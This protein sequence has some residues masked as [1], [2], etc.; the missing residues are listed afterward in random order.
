MRTPNIQDE[1]WKKKI[2]TQRNSKVVIQ[3]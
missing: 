3:D 2:I 1:Q